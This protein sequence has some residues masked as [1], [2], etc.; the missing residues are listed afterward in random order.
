VLRVDTEQFP[1]RLDLAARLGP[2]EPPRLLLDGVQVLASAVW[3]W[4]LWP[5]ALDSA[6][7]AEHAAQ[8]A[9]ESAATLNGFLDL[10]D[11]AF[12][13]DPPGAV[14]AASSKARQLRLANDHG[15]RLPPTLITRSGDA[16]RA[17][18]SEHDGQVVAKLQTSLTFQM[19]GGGG[20]PTRRLLAEDLGALDALRHCPMMLQRLIPKRWEKRVM[21]V[22][23]RAFVGALAGAD[24]GVDGRY[25]GPAWWEPG[26]LPAE[27]HAR[28]ARLMDSLGLRQGA[29]DLIETPDG[30]HVFLEVNPTGEWGMLEAELGLPIGDAIAQALLQGAKAT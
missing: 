15:L 6:L 19:T 26:S 9:R 12:W 28:L 24:S 30:E 1:E 16:A 8:S 4:R 25:D 5:A 17:F 22:D 11:G 10:L 13:L 2:G 29:I 7:S 14:H 20:L 21:W 23:G 3:L 27:V 18:F